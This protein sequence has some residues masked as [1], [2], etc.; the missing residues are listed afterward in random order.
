M[1]ERNNVALAPYSLNIKHVFH[2]EEGVGR[3]PPLQNN[4]VINPNLAWIRDAT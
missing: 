4:I 2:V 1:F 3:A